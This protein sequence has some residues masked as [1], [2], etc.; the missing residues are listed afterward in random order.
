MIREQRHARILSILRKQGVVSMEELRRCMPDV[1]AVTLR[2]DLA[3]LDE[4]G[5]IRR[6]HGG[7]V[8]PDESLVRSK[9][10]LPGAEASPLASDLASLNAVILPPISGR[11]SEALRRDII[12]RGIP[13]IAE[14][15]PQPGG[16]YLGPDNF[17]AGVE[18]GRL[19]AREVEGKPFSMLVI[20]VAELPN[21]RER[22]AGFE[23][24]LAEAGVKP[25]AIHRVNGQGSYRIGLRVAHDAFVADE[26][27]NLVFAVNDH[28]AI[29]GIEAA[30]RLDR[31]V[32]VYSMGGESAGFM[33]RLAESGPLKAVGALF[34]EVVGRLGID[35]AVLGILGQSLSDTVTPHAIITPRTLGDYFEDGPDGW[36]LKEDVL[37]RLSSVRLGFNAKLLRSRRIGFLPHYPA[38]DWYRSMASAMQARCQDY[39]ATLVVSPPHHGISAEI[40]RLRREIAQSATLLV[41][42]G[43]VV[44]LNEGQASLFLAEELRSL[45]ASKPERLQG[46]TVVTNSFD[47]LNALEE[48]PTV[49]VILTGGEYQKADRCLVGPSLGAI[50]ERVR[51]H[52]AFIAVDGATPGFG[53]SSLDERRALAA[54]RLIDAAEVSI[55]LADSV[56]LGSDANHR[57]AGAAQIRSVLTDDGALP[58]DRQRFRSVGV[59]VL[60]AGEVLPEPAV[61]T[62]GNYRNQP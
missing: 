28:A 45:A 62:V 22:V 6:R 44:A 43:M 49:K 23:T 18:L 20:S 29:A 37:D 39:G 41:R 14:S 10:P 5:A 56:A 30:Q 35:M 19:A 11:G 34:P 17:A 54:Q 31:Q 40:A 24:G 57:I 8:L 25:A 55:V 36:R 61:D 32:A 7:A 51:P 59:D 4:L 16:V 27:I 2:R 21:T 12:R 13:F 46:V 53:L 42:A 33:A 58:E 38:H 60:I 3:Q 15:A 26:T 52:L 9:G 48:I 50:F 1:A 47:V